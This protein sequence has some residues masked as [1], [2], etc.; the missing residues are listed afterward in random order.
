MGGIREGIPFFI[1]GNSRT[2][3]QSGLDV[4]FV[5]QVVNPK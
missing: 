3:P 5:S 2:Y 1:G 4:Y